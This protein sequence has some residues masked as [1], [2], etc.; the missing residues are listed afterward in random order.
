MKNNYWNL[1]WVI[2]GIIIIASTFVSGT[3]TRRVLGFEMNSWIYRL[4]WGVIT[5]LSLLNFL[6][7]RK[8]EKNKV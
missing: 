8:E 3:E 6:R 1:A 5:V 2:L 7:R 4:I